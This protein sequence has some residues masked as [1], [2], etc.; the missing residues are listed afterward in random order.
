MA[1]NAIAVKKELFRRLAL[2][3]GLSGVTVSYVLS[4]IKLPREIVYGGKVT[5]PVTAAAMRPAGGRLGREEIP[6]INVHVRVLKPGVLDSSAEERAAAL[7]TVI[8]DM[9]A[10]DPTLAGAVPGLLLLAVE[11][12]EY[13]TGPGEDG[14]AVAVGTLTL[15]AH[16]F[17]S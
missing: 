4:G 13:E 16:S 1:T 6:L 5:G 11:N 3:P 8:A 17:L 15:S 14:S 12:E 9:V 2:E 7:G 10:A